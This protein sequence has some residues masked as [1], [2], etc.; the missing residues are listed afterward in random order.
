MVPE[1]R[2]KT[3][4]VDVKRKVPVFETKT[5]TEMVPQI[6]TRTTF[7]TAT[8]TVADIKIQ[9][10]MT[11]VAE[12]RTKTV[13]KTRYRDV[14]VNRTETYWENVPETRYKTTLVK[15]PRQIQR[16]HVRAYTVQIPYQVRVCVPF[17]FCRMVP[18]TILIPIETCCDQCS[19]HFDQLH[20]VS[21]AYLNYG[22]HHMGQA[23]DRMFNQ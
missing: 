18:K 6:K 22:I 8:R 23:W 13:Y 10:Y 5:V 14:P 15:V 1:I 12:V 16:D 19:Q 2:T 11:N 20:S 4:Y 7:R 17:K 21:G 9:T 3:E